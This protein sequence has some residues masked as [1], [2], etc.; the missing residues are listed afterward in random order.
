MVSTVT[1]GE[2]E[3]GCTEVGTGS[4]APESDKEKRTRWKGSDLPQV[5]Q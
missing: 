5:T 1:D 2:T 3:A 4:L